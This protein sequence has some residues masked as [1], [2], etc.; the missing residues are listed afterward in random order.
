MN[1][2]KR[3]E[4]LA[5]SLYL[6]CSE[7]VTLACTRGHSLGRSGSCKCSI[8]N[9]LLAGKGFRNTEFF[10]WGKNEKQHLQS[11]K[12]SKETSKRL[13]RGLG[14][15]VGEREWV[16]PGTPDWPWRAHW[17]KDR[18][19]A[20]DQDVLFTASVS[21]G[22]DRSQVIITSLW[23]GQGRQ[24]KWDRYYETLL[25]CFCSFCTL[26]NGSEKVLCQA[27]LNEFWM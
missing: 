16:S 7:R 1:K 5:D 10:P 2:H 27:F 24:E 12:H 8:G 15:I 23:K 11:G 21:A 22:H 26:L 20:G 13:C 3:S 4:C 6:W 9:I 19:R 25:A 17:T 18:K 14:W